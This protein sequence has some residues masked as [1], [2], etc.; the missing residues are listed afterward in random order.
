MTTPTDGDVANPLTVL[1]L[2]IGGALAL[3]PDKKYLTFAGCTLLADADAKS[4]WHPVA[5]S[6]DSRFLVVDTSTIASEVTPDSLDTDEPLSALRDGANVWISYGS[7]LDFIT[8]G[9]STGT[10]IADFPSLD[11]QI[12]NGQLYATVTLDGTVVAV[13]SGLP[14]SLA[15]GSPLAGNAVAGMTPSRYSSGFVFFDLATDG[16]SAPNRLYVANTSEGLQRWDLVSGSWQL[17][18]TLVSGSGYAYVTGFVS[19]G[20]TVTL[21][22]TTADGSKIVRFVDDGTAT[23]DAGVAGTVLVYGPTDDT[24]AL[25]QVYRGVSLPPQ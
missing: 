19:S 23:G 1:G 20:T 3:S 9:A 25:T 10:F 2:T 18:D 14:T 15:D 6:V 12:F 8:F 17:T 16:A 5:A 13:G 7:G 22:A 4:V 24:G 11:L 21:I